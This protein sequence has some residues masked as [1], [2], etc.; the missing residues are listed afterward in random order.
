M[1]CQSNP[2]PSVA[3]RSRNLRLLCRRVFLL[4]L[5][6]AVPALATQARNSW[7]LPQSSPGHFLTAA[8]KTVVPPPVVFE[9][10]PMQPVVSVFGVK[11][12][13]QRICTIQVWPAIRSVDVA[14]PLQ[15]RPP[16]ARFV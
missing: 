3:K 6:F 2:V 10:P 15:F 7:Y 8:S 1:H 9:A 13:T 12:P 16:P 4:F 14:T 5:L 11:P